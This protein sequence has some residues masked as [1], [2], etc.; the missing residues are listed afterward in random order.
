MCHGDFLSRMSNT[1]TSPKFIIPLRLRDFFMRNCMRLGAIFFILCA[2][3]LNVVWAFGVPQKSMS[4]VVKEK[5]VDQDLNKDLKGK[6]EIA[7]TSFILEQEKILSLLG[8]PSTSD[9]EFTLEMLIKRSTKY[10]N[11][12]RDYSFQHEKINNPELLKSNCELLIAKLDDLEKLKNLAELSE[13]NSNA[14]FQNDSASKKFLFYVSDAR[15]FVKTLVRLL[16]K[17]GAFISMK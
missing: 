8:L 3:N 16:E 13:S 17:N 11:L 4:K 5:V 10:S 12:I 15:N 6:A 2:C 7:L 1:S 14:L 9:A